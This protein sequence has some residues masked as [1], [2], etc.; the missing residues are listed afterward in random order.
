MSR[1]LWKKN[2]YDGSLLLIALGIGVCAFSWFRVKIVGKL[3]TGRF[4]QIIDLL[5]DDWQRFATVEFDW[6]VSY[7]GRTATTLE[8]PMLQM[9]VAIWAIVRGSDV[10]SG[11]LSRGTMEMMLSQPVS[12]VRY[13]VIHNVVTLI[14]LFLLSLLIWL[15]MTI[16]VLTVSVQETVYPEIKIPLTS[17][18]VPITMMEPDL[19]QVPMSEHVNPFN[20]WP[21]ILNVFCFGFFLTGAT[22]LLS[23]FDRFRWRTLGIAVGIYFLSGM[24]KIGSMASDQFAFL[25]YLTYFSFYDAVRFIKLQNED[26]ASQLVFLEWAESGEFTGLGPLGC[27]LAFLGLGVLFLL[28]GARVFNRRDL[29]APV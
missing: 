19:V 24:A 22:A 6:M 10:V 26:S 20:F 27:N 17:I 1:A 21:G 8:E 5:P 11:A 23:A 25:K 14:G 2:I 16:A 13:F 4:K 28:I 18:R 29:P 7:L 15:G 9:L 12:R 3:D